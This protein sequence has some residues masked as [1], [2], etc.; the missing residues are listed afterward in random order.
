MLIRG[1]SVPDQGPAISYPA[2]CHSYGPL[3]VAPGPAGL[4]MGLAMRGPG[5]GWRA[6][7]REKSEYLPALPTLLGV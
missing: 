3:N 2:L 4:R 1:L 7:G 6:R 5:R